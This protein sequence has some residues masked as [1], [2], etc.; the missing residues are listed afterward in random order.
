MVTRQNM[1]ESPPLWLGSVH[2]LPIPTLPHLVILFSFSTHLPVSLYLVFVF[3]THFLLCFGPHD[4][5]PFCNILSFLS[6]S[7]VQLN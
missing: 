1:I 6:V 4:F 5:E 7:T 3:A 2:L